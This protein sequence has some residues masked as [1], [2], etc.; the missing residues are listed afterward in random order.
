MMMNPPNNPPHRR[1]PVLLAGLLAASVMVSSCESTKYA[2]KTDEVVEVPDRY[3]TPEV[4]GE[5]LDKWCT[6]FDSPELEQL[7]AQSYERNLDLKAAWARLQ[8]AE[9]VARQQGAP[10]WPWLSADGS[11]THQKTDFG[12]QFGGELPTGGQQ[13][14]GGQQPDGGGEET[15]FFDTS[16]SFTTYRTSLAASYEV[17]V[18][19][20]IRSRWQAAKL[21][22]LATRAQAESLAMTLTSQI[23][24]NWL[25]MVYQR[26]R[27]D[28]IEE[29]IDTSEKFYE[30]TLLRL[31]QGT[32][33]ALDVTQQ[34][35][36]LESLR[37][38]LA[39]ARASE[40]TARNQLAVLLGYAPQQDLGLER[41]QLPDLAPLPDPGVPAELLTRR[42]DVRAAMVRVE[43]ADERIEAAVAEQLPQLQLSASLF[44]QA[45]EIANLFDQLLYNLSAS[46]SQPIFQGGRLRAQIDQTEAAGAEAVFSYAQTLLTAMR[47]VQDA[48]IVESRQGEFI[49]SLRAQLAAAERALELARDRYRRGALDY[50]RVLDAIQSLQI[51]QQN[52]LDARRQRLST[53]IRLCRALGGT[54]TEELTPS[55]GAQP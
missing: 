30:L 18:W 33:T 15:D 21:D 17:D 37:G 10:L 6:D 32:A 48:L 52:L 5:P 16:D 25:D 31:S 14:G 3:Q 26:E 49:E 54:W 34:K 40:A 55:E 28:L 35:Q 46:L 7:V 20:K 2:E 24:E 23:A 27:I 36:N 50:L 45:N 9:A 29:Q 39:L 43:A 41:Q 8:Q 38:Q 47:E 22:A 12:A 19:G 13:P 44:L 1:M 4:T 53:R 42:P 11:A 51:S